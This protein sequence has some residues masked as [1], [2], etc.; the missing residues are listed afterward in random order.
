MTEIKRRLDYNEKMEEI[1]KLVEQGAILYHFRG[2]IKNVSKNIPKIKVYIATII[3]TK[4]IKKEDKFFYRIRNN[5]SLNDKFCGSINIE[6]ISPNELKKEEIV[7]I[8][9]E[10]YHPILGDISMSYSIIQD[11][12]NENKRL[13]DMGST[14][15][16]LGFGEPK[17]NIDGRKL[18]KEE[19][20]GECLKECTILN[21]KVPSYSDYNCKELKKIYYFKNFKLDFNGEINKLYE[22]LLK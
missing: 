13:F 16:F 18:T 2:E 8:A 12:M 19:F 20:L 14:K 21:K 1:K 10:S 7:T 22:Q 11:T 4:P 17:I 3:E 9:K 6:I 5:C 15:G